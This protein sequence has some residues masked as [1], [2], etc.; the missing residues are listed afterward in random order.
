MLSPRGQKHI[1]A[2]SAPLCIA[3]LIGCIPHAT[4]S[5]QA[6]EPSGKTAGPPPN[7]RAAG[8]PKVSASASVVTAAKVNAM[9]E[10]LAQ[11]TR[12]QLRL[13]IVG[14]PILHAPKDRNVIYDAFPLAGRLRVTNISEKKLEIRYGVGSVSRFALHGELLDERGK[15]IETPDGGPID[16]AGVRY[17]DVKLEP[18]ESTVIIGMPHYILHALSVARTNYENALAGKSQGDLETRLQVEFHTSFTVREGGSETSVHE[19][20]LGKLTVQFDT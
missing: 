17:E 15:P 16:P 4:P 18:G 20:L 6:G 1:L 14:A 12:N 5:K 11:S 2:L 8:H 10:V 13:E 9:G 19:V 7:D 3:M